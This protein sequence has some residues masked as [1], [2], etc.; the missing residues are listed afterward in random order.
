M[1]F[2]LRVSTRFLASKDRVWAHKTDVEELRREFLPWIHL[3]VAEPEAL[4]AALAGQGLPQ[5]VDCRVWGLFWP[6]QVTECV[7]GERFCDRSD[8]ALFEQWEHEHRF[9]QA[10]DATFY[11]D[12]ITFTPRWGPPHLVARAVEALFVHRHRR[13][14]AELPTEAKATAVSMLREL[15][16]VQQDGSEGF[17]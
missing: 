9:E 6:I 1:R 4:A 13:A 12:A 15:I 7:P 5:T 2:H 10:S 11:L 3:S 8:N 16:D 14:A 17:L